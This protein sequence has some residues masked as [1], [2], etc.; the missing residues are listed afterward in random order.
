MKILKRYVLREL[1]GPTILGLL[2]FTFLLF[3]TRIFRL[4][5]IL[6]S[7]G[8]DTGLVLGFAACLLPALFTFTV[9][10]AVLVGVLISFGRLT[11]DNEILA[12]R[13]S[14]IHLMTI[15]RPIIL[16]GVFVSI[17]MMWMNFSL[18]PNLN[19]KSNEYLHQIEFQLYN[20]L[21]PNRFYD[22]L[23]SGGAD[24]TLYFSGREPETGTLNGI[25]MKIISNA[26]TFTG[27]EEIQKEGPPE[28]KE[29]LLL[30]ERG[31]L[32][33][34][35]ETRSIR[36]RLYNGSFHPLSGDKSQNT[37]IYFDEL[38]RNISPEMDR[39][40]GG[41][42]Y[43]KEREMTVPELKDKINRIKVSDPEEANESRVA[44]FQRFSNPLACLAF[45]LIGMPLA[46][47]IRPSGKSVG[48]AVSFGLLFFYYLLM[49]W[50]ASIGEVGHRLTPLAVFSPNIILGLIGSVLIYLQI[51]K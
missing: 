33:T 44:L 34:E 38:V 18:L 1:I 17:L 20:T 8:I 10:S 22:E 2:F 19:Y 35:K 37:V 25:M 23:G 36:F 13:T 27:E 28:K 42:Y 41:V 51:R 45:I 46:I 9:P 31:N 26:S 16:F 15:F 12:V 7:E 21:R 43:K 3:I 6:M 30:A 39:V 32:S 48:F 11:T 47:Y 4:A 29:T 40:Y 24:I 50:G 5:D 49:K 14:G